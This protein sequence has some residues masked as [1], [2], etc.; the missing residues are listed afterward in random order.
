MMLSTRPE[1]SKEDQETIRSQAQLSRFQLMGEMVINHR[2]PT[3]LSEVEIINPSKAEFLLRDEVPLKITRGSHDPVKVSCR[4]IVVPCNL[5]L[6]MLGVAHER[7]GRHFGVTCPTQLIQHQFWLGLHEIVKAYLASCHPCPISGNYKQIVPRASLQL[8]PSISV[9]ELTQFFYWYGFL[10]TFQKDEGSHFMA[11]ESRPLTILI[12]HF[13]L[14]Q[15]QTGILN[16]GVYLNFF[17]TWDKLQTQENELS[18]M[19]SSLEH[20]GSY[21]ADQEFPLTVL[22]DHNPLTYLTELCNGNKG[23]MRWGIDLQNYNWKVKR[24]KNS[25]ERDVFSRHQCPMHN[26]MTIA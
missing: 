8:I 2:A 23:L 4:Q 25:G 16:C 13:W 15:V 1:V 7:L 14:Y 11:E 17:Q 12:I 10:A 19:G 5:R 9:T 20:L 3:Y 26:A 18:G 24:L 6:S 21:C 22:K